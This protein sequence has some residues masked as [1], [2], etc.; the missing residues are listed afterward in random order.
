MNNDFESDLLKTKTVLKNLT[1]KDIIINNKRTWP[2][3]VFE[4]LK[5]SNCDMIE[6]DLA[7]YLSANNYSLIGIHCTRLTDFEIVDIKSNGLEIASKE[8]F[9]KKINNL[10]N[11]ISKAIKSELTSHINSLSEIQAKDQIC[12]SCG[13]LDLKKDDKLDKIFTKNWGGETIYNYYDRNGGETDHQRKIGNLINRISYPCLI[14]IKAK[15]YSNTSLYNEYSSLIRQG[16][17]NCFKR[18]STSFYIKNKEVEVLDIIN[19]NSRL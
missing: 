3:E 18:L 4:I 7:H 10:P 16:L 13:F 8:L 5:K 1:N 9:I 6:S 19:I 15:I 14:I 11:T 12:C 2:K 17:K